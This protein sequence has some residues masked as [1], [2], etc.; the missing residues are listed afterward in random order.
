MCRMTHALKARNPKNWNQI[1]GVGVTGQG[2]GLWPID[3]DGNPVRNAI[4]WNDTR[5]KVIDFEGMDALN[6]AVRQEF[7]NAVYAGSV[8]ALLKWMKLYEPHDYS[9]IRWAL[10][11]KDWLN[12]K[13][14]GKV[15]TDFTDAST[16]LFNI[17]KGEFSQKILDVLGIPE[18][19]DILPEVVE[20][21]RVIGHIS[22]E[23]SE[24]TGICEGTPVIEGAIDVCTVALGTDVKNVGDSCT[25]IGTT[26]GSEVIIDPKDMDPDEK[27][28]LLMHNV[29]PNTY[30]WILPT[31]SGASTMDFNQ[32]HRYFPTYPIRN[33][34]KS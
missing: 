28:G 10:H 19:R 7:T 34:K 29:V 14:T 1:A 21:T 23:V 30:L 8:A 32:V 31:L 26:L 5:S 16:T 25:I 9:R 12:Y 13:L 18:C 17:K 33:W 15:Y 22:R 27:R 4:L 11:C 24:L 2:D 6:D 20:S 3:K